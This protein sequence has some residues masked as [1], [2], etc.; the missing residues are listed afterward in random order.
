MTLVTAEPEEIADFASGLVGWRVLSVAPIRR[1]G[2]NR[3][4]QL[5]GESERAVLKV[6]PTQVEDP[7]DRL[8]QEFTALSFLGEAGITEVP[9]PIACDRT[10]SCAAYEWIDGVPPG[11]VGPAE[12]DE[13]ADFFLQ[14]Q[15]L[16][17]RPGAT[18][19]AEGATPALSAASV[20]T[21]LSQRLG[22]LLQVISPES[23]VADFVTHQ[24]IA[25]VESAVAQ[26]RRGCDAAGIAFERPLPQRLRVL[27]P[28]DFGFHNALRRPN[29]R[30]AFLDFEYFGWDEPSKAVA[31]VMLHAGMSLPNELARRYRSRITGALQQWD[32]GFPNRF[33]TFFPCLRAIWCLILLN[34]F[35]PERWARRQLAGVTDDR[36]TAE[37]RQLKKAREMLLRELD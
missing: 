31:D 36:A 13:L 21:Q 37:A 11:V 3:I 20:A 30:L 27:S 9:R 1:G 19:L 28:S 16:R 35:L 6:Y 17:E 25:E 32:P 5:Q 10:R 18:G 12:V 33:A 14:L 23:E 24:L 7:R 26:L 22:R 8:G 34:E 4:F 15:D 29:G 2:N